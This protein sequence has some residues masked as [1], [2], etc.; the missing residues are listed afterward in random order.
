MQQ[1]TSR[2]RQARTPS[3]GPY[4][5]LYRHRFLGQC[6]T[7]QALEVELDPEALSRGVDEAGPCTHGR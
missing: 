5:A 7:F 3:R 4:L 2:I 1:P 6:L